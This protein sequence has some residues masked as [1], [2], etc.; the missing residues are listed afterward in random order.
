L[1]SYGRVPASLEAPLE[2]RRGGVVN[3]LEILKQIYARQVAYVS[4]NPQVLANSDRQQEFFEFMA[5]VDSKFALDIIIEREI[6]IA[7][8]VSSYVQGRVLDWGCHHGLS[9]CLFR[10]WLGN[11]VELH[12]C[13]VFEGDAYKA[14]H[15]YSEALYRRLTHPYRLEYEDSFF[16]VVLSN[17][18]LEHVPNEV[19]SIREI[20]R[21]LKPGG[22]FVITALPNRYSY[23]EAVARLRGIACHDRLY[24]PGSLGRTL[25]REGFEVVASKHFFM[26]PTMLLGFPHMVRDAY[27]RARGLVR[28]SNRALEAAWPLNRLASNLMVVA[29][30]S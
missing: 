5:Y 25:S 12:G 15:D 18:V 30:K 26:L 7:R 1:D 13:D 28:V 29:A 24:T 16:D 6:R 10:M 2:L 20:R 17:G 11:A 22:E 9:L 14:F 23:T 4:A 19:E 8:M 27:N 3:E 21:I